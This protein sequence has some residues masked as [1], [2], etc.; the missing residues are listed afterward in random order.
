MNCNKNGKLFINFLVAAIYQ[1]RLY[2]N[3][4]NLIPRLFWK[5]GNLELYE[6]GTE[7]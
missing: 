3:H 1:V 7:L 2:P 6:L 4:F 5:P